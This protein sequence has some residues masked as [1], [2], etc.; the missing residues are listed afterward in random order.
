MS[1]NHLTKH[2][3]CCRLCIA[4][5]DSCVIASI[6]GESEGVPI[7]YLCQCAVTDAREPRPAKE[8]K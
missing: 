2:A 7:C 4:Y 1:T 5:S 3:K 8:A 6:R